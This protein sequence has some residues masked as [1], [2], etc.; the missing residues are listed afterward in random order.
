MFSVV[1]QNAFH[2][3][4]SRAQAQHYILCPWEPE[5]VCPVRNNNFPFKAGIVLFLR[6]AI[7]QGGCFHLPPW[8]SFSF[9][10]SSQM[11]QCLQKLHFSCILATTNWFC[12]LPPCPSVMDFC[13]LQKEMI[14]RDY[15]VMIS[16]I[17]S[18]NHFIF[19]ATNYTVHLHNRLQ[20]VLNKSVLSD[21][22]T[23]CHSA[24]DA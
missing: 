16:I 24:P 4:D 3:F 17:S 1:D 5:R 23:G 13:V 14:M 7:T 8:C 10:H 22:P 20:H 18:N 15:V 12:F 6:V 9:L 21:A 19:L 11:F 2:S